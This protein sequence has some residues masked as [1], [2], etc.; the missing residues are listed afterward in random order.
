MWCWTDGAISGWGIFGIVLM[1]A[2]WIAV[3]VL[4]IWGIR[5]LTQQKT[6]ITNA[7]GSLEIAKQRYARGEISEHEY[8]QIKRDLS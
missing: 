6:I 1:V 3:I 5:H 2:F 7:G 4:V 8:D